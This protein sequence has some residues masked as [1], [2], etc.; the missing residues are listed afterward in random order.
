MSGRRLPAAKN[1]CPCQPLSI[2]CSPEI[3]RE[4]FDIMWE[5]SKPGSE[6]EGLFLRAEHKDYFA[7]EPDYSIPYKWIPNVRF[8]RHPRFE[9]RPLLTIRP[10]SIAPNRSSG[11]NRPS[12][13]L[14][15]HRYRYPSVFALSLGSVPRQRGSRSSQH[16]PAHFPSPR[17]RSDA[18]QA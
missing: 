12:V 17:R 18:I 5:M 7:V 4:T 3:N 14:Y 10:V 16:A 6:T 8:P 13:L 9:S 1:L 15:H 2:F 11:G